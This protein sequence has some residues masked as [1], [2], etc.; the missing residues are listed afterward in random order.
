MGYRESKQKILLGLPCALTEI[1]LGRG[2]NLDFPY[3]CQHS[4]DF[5][6]S[7]TFATRK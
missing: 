1:A 3:A 4:T 7:E 2:R 5:G 6:I